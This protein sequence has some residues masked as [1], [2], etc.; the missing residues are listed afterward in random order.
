MSKNVAWRIQN[1][2][3][4]WFRNEG[5]FETKKQCEVAIK[6]LEDKNPE[7]TGILEAVRC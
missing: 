2:L 5:P 3:T 6:N 1:K 7:F 4:K